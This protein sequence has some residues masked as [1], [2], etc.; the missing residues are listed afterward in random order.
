M[1][2]FVNPIACAGHGACAELVPEL[3]E[4]DEWGY[5]V[6]AAP[7]VPA[8]LERRVRKAVSACPALA[9]KLR[10]LGPAGHF[11]AGYFLAGHVLAGGHSTSWPGCGS[12]GIVP[13][14][15]AW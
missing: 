12:A 8:Q 2:L 5:P 4:L 1:N 6:I 9:L 13:S 15:P 3:I 14:R 10:Q 11:L 7:E